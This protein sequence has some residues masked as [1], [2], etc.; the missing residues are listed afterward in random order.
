M[1]RGRLPVCLAR[2]RLRDPGVIDALRPVVARAMQEVGQPGLSPDID[3]PRL[4]RLEDEGIAVLYTLRT[5]GAL[6]GYC[7]QLVQ[8]H[9]HYAELVAFNDA[10][11]I[12]PPWR[13]RW[14][15]R[16]VR[17]VE[18]A[19]RAL[20]CA[21]IYWHGKPVNRLL[22]LLRRMGYADLESVLFKDLRGAA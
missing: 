5:D 7:L 2:E 14:G 8:R 9:V 12:D 3:W 13:A 1:T 19:M 17:A 21:R 4:C 16:L 20:G 6:V 18:V 11:W 15:V 22:P 10:L